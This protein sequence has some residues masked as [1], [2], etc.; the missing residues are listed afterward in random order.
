MKKQLC[1]AVL[2]CI[3][4]VTTVFAQKARDSAVIDP[5]VHHVMFENEHVR[6]IDARAAPGWKSAMHAH[7]PMVFVNF[8]TARQKVIAPDGKTR[9]VD[10]NPG[11]VLWVDQP[12]DHSWELLSGDVHAI[13]IEVKSASPKGPKPTPQ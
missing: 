8:G 7:A 10:L 13:L 12:F 1:V 3:C 9:L 5:A 6:V 4:G 11:T 2:L